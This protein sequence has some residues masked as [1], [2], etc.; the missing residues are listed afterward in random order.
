MHLLKESIG[1]IARDIPG[2]TTIFHEFGLDF[3]CAGSKILSTIIAE[4]G[5]DEDLVI[6]KLNT[7]IEQENNS[8]DWKDVKNDLLITHILNRYHDVHREQLP[9]LIRLANRVELVHSQH[10]ECPVGLTNHL[11]EISK[12]LEIHMK[13][14]EDEVFHLIRADA[15]AEAYAFIQKLQKEHEEH[16]ALLETIEKMTNNI[17]TPNGA[18]NTWQALYKGLHAFKLDLM[19]HIHLENNILFDRIKIEDL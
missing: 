8:L 4:K 18:C 1:K 13:C 15:T 16:G 7:L 17:S 2:A 9:E 6:K 12:N 14:E 3:C 10:P 5:V 19:Q 11:K